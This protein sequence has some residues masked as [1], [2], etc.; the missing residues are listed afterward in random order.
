VLPDDDTHSA[1]IKEYNTF[2]LKTITSSGRGCD[3]LKQENINIDIVLI[4]L[5]PGVINL[6]K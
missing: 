1:T 3:A 2:N 6:N 4:Y 5:C